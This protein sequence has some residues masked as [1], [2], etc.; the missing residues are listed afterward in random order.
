VK[1]SRE[2]SIGGPRPTLQPATPTGSPYGNDA[3]GPAGMGARTR[4]KSGVRARAPRFAVHAHPFC[5]KI[6]FIVLAKNVILLP[7]KKAVAP[8]LPRRAEARA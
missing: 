7:E 6:V 4:K 8:P 2:L 5:E 3:F 1:E